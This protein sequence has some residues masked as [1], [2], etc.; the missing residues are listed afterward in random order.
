MGKDGEFSFVICSN[1][2]EKQLFVSSLNMAKASERANKAKNEF[3]D[4]LKILLKAS[5]SSVQNMGMR[6]DMAI[7][8]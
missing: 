3:V 5:D 6:E 1:E 8:M 4:N 2:F 7:A